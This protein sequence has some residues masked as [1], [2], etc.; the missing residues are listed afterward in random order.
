VFL[1]RPATTFVVDMSPDTAVHVSQGP[2]PPEW[3][4]RG[5][6][7]RKRSSVFKGEPGKGL[8]LSA[9]VG[10]SSISDA[11]DLFCG[12]AS[13]CETG[14]GGAVALAAD[15]WILPFL[16]AHVGYLN[17]S[18]F[19]VSGKG[20]TFSFDSKL[21][22]RILTVG[23][24]VGGA[25]GPTRLYGLGGLDYS[26]ATSTTTNTITDKT[27]T[28]NGVN[29]TV[30]GGT[31]SFGQKSKGRSWYAGGGVEAW[32]NSWVG[33]YSELIIANIKGTPEG[34]GEGGIDDRT[35]AVLVGA[36]VRIGR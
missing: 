19:T 15:V 23:A 29:Q 5:E 1:M 17:P 10:L 21:Q 9:G 20:D 14:G 11:T 8:V 22:T 4:L 35:I 3:I 36:R 28:V 33:I 13:S 6:E 27:I 30:T 31:Q 25:V 2:P 24:K 7:A 12:T 26:Q 34:G 32:I 16:A 18:A